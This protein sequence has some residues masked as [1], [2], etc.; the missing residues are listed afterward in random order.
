MV[1]MVEAAAAATPVTLRVV[2]L[3]SKGAAAV[4]V[5]EVVLPLTEVCLSS[6]SYYLIHEAK[7]IMSMLTFLWE[8]TQVL[9]IS[10]STCTTRN[11]SMSEDGYCFEFKVS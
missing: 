6:G 9:F 1:V 2:V 4:I 3:P 11:S 5:L 8:L 10:R 7:L